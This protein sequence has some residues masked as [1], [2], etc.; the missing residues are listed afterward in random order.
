[1]S[2]VVV[3]AGGA[4]SEAKMPISQIKAESHL[5]MRELLV[6]EQPGFAG[7]LG[8]SKAGDSDA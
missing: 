5:H 4:V 1:M 7:G 2:I 3:D 6:V 8:A